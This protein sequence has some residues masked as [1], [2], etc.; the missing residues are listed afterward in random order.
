[1]GLQFILGLRAGRNRRSNSADSRHFGSV[2]ENIG[3]CG[4]VRLDDAKRGRLE[5]ALLTA[6][7][8]LRQFLRTWLLDVKSL[9]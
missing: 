9:G 5:F 8:F 3:N 4:V 1:M 2:R 7:I 6:F